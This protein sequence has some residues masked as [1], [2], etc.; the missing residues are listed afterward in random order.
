MFFFI[1]GLVFSYIDGYMCTLSL[2]MV[3]LWTILFSY[4]Y[5]QLH[6]FTRWGSVMMIW[7]ALLIRCICFL[8]PYKL[9]LGHSR[10]RAHIL[11]YLFAS[12]SIATPFLLA[13]VPRLH[14]AHHQV[15]RPASKHFPPAEAQSCPR[16]TRWCARGFKTMAHW[17]AAFSLVAGVYGC[18]VV[19]SGTGRYRGVSRLQPAFVAD[20]RRKIV[21]WMRFVTCCCY[22]VCRSWDLHSCFSGAVLWN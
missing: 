7:Y 11:T 3:Y 15:L 22:I 21:S 2:C 17:Y 1:F 6:I 4:G 8:H 10:C 18:I 16:R 9:L 19:G 14:G 12:L 20:G 5:T 13:V